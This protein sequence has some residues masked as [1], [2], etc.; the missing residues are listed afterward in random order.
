MREGEREKMEENDENRDP[1][2][3]GAVGKVEEKS[4]RLESTKA[5]KERSESSL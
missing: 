4:K 3:S 2:V 1:N 5:N